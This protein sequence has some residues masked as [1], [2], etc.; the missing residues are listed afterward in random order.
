MKEKKRNK[1][2]CMTAVHPAL[3]VYSLSLSFVCVWVYDFLFL[4]VLFSLCI[5]TINVRA[6]FI[7]FFPYYFRSFRSNSASAQSSFL[8]RQQ[9]KNNTFETIL[10]CFV[11]VHFFTLYFF[12]IIIF[13]SFALKNA[14]F[15]AVITCSFFIRSQC[16]L[17]I[18][19]LSSKTRTHSTHFDY[20][21]CNWL[22]VLTLSSSLL[23]TNYV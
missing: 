4:A 2:N 11:S 14:A 1:N 18:I 17:F 6:P 10:F 15:Y 13:F 20:L 3:S 9:L 8:R 21:T 12:W 7:F 19:F 22:W 5:R 16:L 23:N